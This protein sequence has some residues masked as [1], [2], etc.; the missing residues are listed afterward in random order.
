MTDLSLR[1]ALIT[2]AKQPQAGQT[3]TR[4]SPPLE[5]AQAAALYECFLQDT[6]DL[7]RQVPRV[8]R[9]LAYLPPEA[10]DYFRTLAPGFTLLLQEGAGLGERLDYATT[11]PLAR[12]CPAVVIMVS[13]SPTL[14]SA[15]LLQAFKALAGA[16]DV[17]IGPCQDGGYYLIGLK[18]PAPR[19]LREVR[20]STLQRLQGDLAQF[21]AHVAPHT[22]RLRSGV[23]R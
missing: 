23:L 13:D 6:L 4:L 16:A 12:G 21:S 22:R 18:R 9:L 19:L 8:A 2:I 10:K 3:K 7:I 20:M 14:P 11:Y 17:V 5:P 15:F 1:R